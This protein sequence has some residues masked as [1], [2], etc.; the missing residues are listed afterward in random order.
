MAHNHESETEVESRQNPPSEKQGANIFA[1]V[2]SVVLTMSVGLMLWV[3]NLVVE[4]GRTLASHD[5]T[6][7]ATD[8]RLDALETHGSS[9]LMSHVT[10]DDAELTAVRARL[11]KI[12]TAIA[13][14]Q[15][16][17]GELRAIAVR[18]EGIKETQARIEHALE[19]I[20]KP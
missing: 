9:S 5:T 20:K 18:L 6:L 13:A 3:A 12:E 19:L 7:R 10:Q 2:E 4:H 14:L 16:T 1:V 17:P 8:N 15:S 11:D